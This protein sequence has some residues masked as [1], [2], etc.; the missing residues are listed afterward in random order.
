MVDKYTVVSAKIYEWTKSDDGKLEV[1]L[2][3]V[4]GAF[5]G[6]QPDDNLKVGLIGQWIKGQLEKEKDAEKAKKAIEL[7]EAL[8]SGRITL[9]VDSRKFLTPPTVLESETSK[10]ALEV[11]AKAMADTVKTK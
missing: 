11:I 1:K 10:K 8:S 6:E 4:S 5:L 2:H 9:D 7:A 3:T